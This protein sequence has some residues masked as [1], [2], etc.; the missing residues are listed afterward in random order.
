MD[1]NFSFLMEPVPSA[2]PTHFHL[3]IHRGI[4]HYLV[5]GRGLTFYRMSQEKIRPTT[6]RVELLNAPAVLFCNL[7]VEHV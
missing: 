2:P 7:S 4:K 5:R 1:V 3:I 6:N